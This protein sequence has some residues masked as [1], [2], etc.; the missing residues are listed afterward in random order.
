MLPAAY[1][2]N[3]SLMSSS[4]LV[5]RGNIV[6][7]CTGFDITGI[8]I[9]NCEDVLV[10]NN[11]CVRL[12]ST[13]G[14]G[15]G[16][17][18][19]NCENV[20]LLYNT[21]SRVDVGFDFSILSSLIMYNATAHNCDICI[22]TSEDAEIR[23]L[24]LSAYPDWKLY[25]NNLGIFTQ[26]GASVDVDYMIYAGI[27][28]LTS[29]NVTVGTT[30]GEKRIMY[31]DEENDDLTPEYVSTLV[32]TGT[33]NGLYDD[34]IDIGGIQSQVKDEETA[35][36]KYFYNMLDN[37]FWD[38]ENE[39][40]AEVSFIKAIQSKIFAYA[41]TEFNVAKNDYYLKTMASSY[42]FSS[43]FPANMRYQTASKF[44]KRVADLFYATQKPGTLES[45]NTGI[46]G[47]NLLPSFFTRIEDAT[48]GW[49]L[50]E[51]AVDVDNW[52]LGY[53]GIRCGI[54]V[55]ML[56]TSTL[57]V[58]ASGE[59][60]NNLTECIAD[61]API[62]LFLHNEVQ[63]SGY[64]MVTDLWNGFENCELTN[65][66]YSDD[67]TIEPNDADQTGTIITPLLSTEEVVSTLGVTPSGDNVQIS[68]L[69]RLRSENVQRALYFRQGTGSGSLG[70][71]EEIENTIGGHFTVTDPLIQF[72]LLIEDNPRAHD[73]EFIGLC[74][75]TYSIARDFTLPQS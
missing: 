39:A 9:E 33:A 28:T 70:A 43:L 64:V 67:F 23:N 11:K 62:K 49:I 13:G 66:H 25:K 61:I 12:H 68:V 50:G 16:F 17:H 58:A 45:L 46:G 34:H 18:I 54:Y 3:V 20:N 41:E 35:K 55:D 7:D 71:W 29:G 47:Y 69:D 36:I 6:S 75:R 30:V 40:A 57:S 1:V 37:S 73:Y 52:L 27:G 32:G 22:Q 59:C 31:V 53:E 2:D 38:V 42:G 10:K 72:K 44:N 74:F 65:M 15:R 14:T 8:K 63:P 48:F 19:T 4:T 21:A 5:N 24:A 56:G 26:G 60:Y 51:S